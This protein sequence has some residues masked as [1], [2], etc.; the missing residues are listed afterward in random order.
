[1]TQPLDE[2]NRL[3]SESIHAEV[4]EKF[5]DQIRKVLDQPPKPP[6]ESSETPAD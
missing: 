2:I 5:G 1:M 3:F 4:E 6:E